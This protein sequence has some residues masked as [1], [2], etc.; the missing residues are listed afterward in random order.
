MYVL[1][2]KENFD[3]KN[4]TFYNYSAMFAIT[5]SLKLMLND[6]I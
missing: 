3:L 4:Q 2:K 1:L 5:S 6:V